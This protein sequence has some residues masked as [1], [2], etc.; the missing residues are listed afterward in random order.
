[1]YKNGSIF[2]A[3]KLF[4]LWSEVSCLSINPVARYLILQHFV[5]F[6]NST[7]LSEIEAIPGQ[8]CNIFFLLK[9]SLIHPVSVPNSFKIT[10][11]VHH[12]KHFHYNCLSSWVQGMLHQFHLSYIAIVGLHS[13]L[14]LDVTLFLVVYRLRTQPSLSI[15]LFNQ[16]LYIILLQFQFANVTGIWL[17]LLYLLFMCIIRVCCNNLDIESVSHLL[18]KGTKNLVDV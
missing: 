11:L 5:E 6:E 7:G 13:D 10:C 8:E 9:L 4:H 16:H 3:L 15:Y 12:T 1:M 18:A 14:D 17:L 2:V